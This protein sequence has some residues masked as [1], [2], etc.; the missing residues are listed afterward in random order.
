[1]NNNEDGNDNNNDYG[2]E[3]YGDGLDDGMGGQ[4]NNNEGG[5]DDAEDPEVDQYFDDAGDIGYLPADHVTLY[6]FMLSASHATP[7]KRSYQAAHR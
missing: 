6:S 1:M 2:Q 3:D 5:A 4:P 7:L